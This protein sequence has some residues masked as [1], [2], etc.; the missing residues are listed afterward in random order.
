M[1]RR[2]THTHSD[3]PRYIRQPKFRYGDQGVYEVWAFVGFQALIYIPTYLACRFLAATSGGRSLSK[4]SASAASIYSAVSKLVQNAN[5][6][7]AG[8]WAFRH[9]GGNEV[10]N[11]LAKHTVA[12][13][14][15]QIGILYGK[16]AAEVLLG[17]NNSGTFRFWCYEHGPCRNPPG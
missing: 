17:H 6:V 16:E 4:V 13:F 7:V 3:A 9:N 14:L 15:M 10:C 11:S 5:I 2:S 8:S 1:Y 12:H